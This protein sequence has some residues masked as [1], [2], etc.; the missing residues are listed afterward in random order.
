MVATWEDAA[1]Q[2]IGGE[3]MGEASAAVL[4]WFTVFFAVVACCAAL[5]LHA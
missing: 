5:S 1:V 3:K 2:S 4:S